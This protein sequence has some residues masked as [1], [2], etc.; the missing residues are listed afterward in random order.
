MTK[1]TADP[2]GHASSRDYG[3]KTHSGGRTGSESSPPRSAL[4]GVRPSTQNG[5]RPSI[6]AYKLHIFSDRIKR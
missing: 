4:G 5:S 3:V 1:G 2:Y 6:V